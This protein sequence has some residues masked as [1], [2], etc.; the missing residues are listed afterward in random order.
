MNEETQEIIDAMML[1]MAD[2]VIRIAKRI[3]SGDLTDCGTVSTLNILARAMVDA[4]TE[5]LKK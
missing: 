4:T 2:V 3:D 5:E 1:R